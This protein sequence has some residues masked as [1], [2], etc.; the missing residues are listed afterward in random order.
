MPLSTAFSVSQSANTPQSVTVTDTSTGSDVNITGRRIYVQDA[1]GNYLTGDGTINY[2]VWVLANASITLPILTED[3]ACNIIVE[4]IDVTNAVLYTLNNNYPLAEFNKQFLF[5]LIQ[6][7]GLTPGIVNDANYSGS[8]AV[9]WTNIIG[10]I[11]AVTFGNDLAGAQNCFN[12]A[13]SM[14]L[15]ENNY[16]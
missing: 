15:Q 3:I 12:R 4:W 7:Q 16:F 1:Y 5:Y 13:T 14:R 9:F 11:N 8:I 6:L 10:G 2:T